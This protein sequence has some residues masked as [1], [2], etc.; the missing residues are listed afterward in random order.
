[1]YRHRALFLLASMVAT[2]LVAQDS[3]GALAPGKDSV[4]T[5]RWLPGTPYEDVTD[6][7]TGSHD[8]KSGG[9]HG[10]PSRN[11]S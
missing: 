11:Q 1:M 7:P 2:P 5:V 10:I 8:A 9:N 3:A 6:W 4:R